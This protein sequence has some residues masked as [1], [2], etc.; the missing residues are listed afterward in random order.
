MVGKTRGRQ[1]ILGHGIEASGWTVTYGSRILATQDRS[2]AK[3][4]GDGLRISR[5]A[6]DDPADGVS[7]LS[8]GGAGAASQ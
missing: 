5:L 7:D 8:F 2:R 1:K 3:N 6:R 4:R